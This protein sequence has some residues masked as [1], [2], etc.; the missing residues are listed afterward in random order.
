[1]CRLC[2]L[3]PLAPYANERAHGTCQTDEAVIKVGP[4]Q[5]R[6]R[7]GDV[8]KVS[9]ELQLADRAL[10]LNLLLFDDALTILEANAALALAE[11]VLGVYLGD[12][13]AEQTDGPEAVGLLL[14]PLGA[15]PLADASGV[16]NGG[17][18]EGQVAG[19]TELAADGE[20]AQDGVE[21]L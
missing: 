16:E 12:G 2:G 10:L 13:A 9:E 19:V 14:G 7:C 1:M 5:S 18:V 6:G 8:A 15:L 21:R 11:L 17:Q 4:A 3:L 20:V